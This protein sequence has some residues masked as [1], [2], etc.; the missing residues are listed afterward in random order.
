MTAFMRA[1]DAFTWAMESDPRLR[2]TVVS[3]V[4]LDRSPDWD[5]VRER[6]DLISR[7]LPMFR[8]RVAPSHPPAP[9]RWEYYRDFDLGYHL[10]RTALREPGTLDDVLQMAQLAAMQDFDRARALWETVLIDGLRG[11]GAAMICKFHH[12]LTDG[13]G[14]VQ[15]AMNLFNL[16]EELREHEPL[17][18]EPRVVT[19]APLSGYRDSWRYDAGMLSGALTGAVKWAPRLVYDGVRRPV[20]TLRAAAATAAS[21]YRTVRPIGRTGSPLVTERGLIRRLGVHQVPMPLLREAAHRCGG[22]LNDAFVAGVAGGLRLYHDKHGVAV[23]DLHLTMPVSLR[24]AADDIGGNRITLMRFD[25]PVGEA[26][27]AARIRAIH[28][29][30]GAVRDERSLPYTQ[31]IAGAL[32]L[33]PRWYIGSVLR[34]VDFLASDVPGVAV[35]VFLGGAAVRAQYAFGPT[36]GSSVNVTLLTYVDTCCLGINVDTA[37]IPDYDVFHDALVGGFDEVLALAS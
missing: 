29:R 25:V 9:P 2:S 7:K 13:I 21:I 27:P 20:G 4:L 11:G 5:E 22:A 12:A 3:V 24:T 34:H 16:T 23:N 32:N 26:D 14:G 10:R 33:M 6:F 18:P 36:I 37:A 35:P 28:R 8:Q 15:I 19:A 30:T 1:S 31:L 17:P